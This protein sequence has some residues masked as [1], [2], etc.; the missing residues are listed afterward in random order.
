MP[1]EQEIRSLLCEL[2][3]NQDCETLDSRID[4]A[5]YGMDSLNCMSLVIALEEAFDIEMPVDKLG[6]RFVRNVYD[7]CKLVEEV[8]GNG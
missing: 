3:E 7:I 2:L 5:P 1:Y 6:M 4:L 8:K